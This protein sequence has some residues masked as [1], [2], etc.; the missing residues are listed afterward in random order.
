MR[1]VL[2]GKIPESLVLEEA[3]LCTSTAL[4]FIIVHVAL[5]LPM[6]TSLE[7]HWFLS[8]KAIPSDVISLFTELK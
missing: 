2:R 5:S 1:G 6:R 4:F 8:F 7:F 3:Q